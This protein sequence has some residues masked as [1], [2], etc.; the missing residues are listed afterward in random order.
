MTTTNVAGLQPCMSS[1]EQQ[2]QV[3]KIS[4]VRAA[5]IFIFL[6][7]LGMFEVLRLSRSKGSKRNV[8]RPRRRRFRDEWKTTTRSQDDDDEVDE[9]K[10]TT[11]TPNDDEDSVPDNERRTTTEVAGLQPCKSSAEQQQQSPKTS[12]VRAALIFIFLRL[13]G[14]FEVLQLSRSEGSKRNVVRRQR[15]RF[16]DEWR[17]TIPDVP[18]KMKT[19]PKTPYDDDEVPDNAW[20]TTTKV[21]GLQPCKSSA[22]QQQQVPKISHVRADLIFI[23]LRL[24]GMFE[25]LRLSRSEGPKRNVDRPYKRRFRDEGRTTIPDVP[26]KMTTETKTETNG[27]EEMPREFNIVSKFVTGTET[28]DRW[29]ADWPAVS[30]WVWL[31]TC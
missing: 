15:R 2:Q 10:T 7:L 25:A 31:L 26:E 8:I 27:D 19:E 4:H 6:R 29:T 18:E 28:P 16:R 5:L 14:M 12:H 11:R 24:L 3:P 20:R 23:F 22:E 21:A 30:V 17:T 9:W 1:A 13:L